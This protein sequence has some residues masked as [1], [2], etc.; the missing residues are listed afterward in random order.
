VITR[1]GRTEGADEDAAAASGAAAGSGSADE[2]AVERA[3]WEDRIL[4]CINRRRERRELR[5]R[6]C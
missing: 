5:T 6:D 3:C 2:G 1:E 4:D